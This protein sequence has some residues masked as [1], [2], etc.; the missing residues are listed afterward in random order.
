MLQVQQHKK[1]WFDTLN[2]KNFR[3]FVYQKD[4]PPNW[5][6]ITETGKCLH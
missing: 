4:N 3:T 1:I 5:K 2:F 6:Q